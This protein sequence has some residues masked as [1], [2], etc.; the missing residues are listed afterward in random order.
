MGGESDIS[1]ELVEEYDY[2]SNSEQEMSYLDIP[3]D[4]AMDESEQN[5]D[6]EEVF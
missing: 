2:N 4:E 6:L 3:E 5:S 1:D